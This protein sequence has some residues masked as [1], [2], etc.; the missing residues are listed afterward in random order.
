MDFAFREHSAED[1]V[2]REMSAENWN[3]IDHL[4]VEIRMKAAV[5]RDDETYSKAD[6]VSA[7]LRNLP[8]QICMEDER[9]P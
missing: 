7:L 4:V 6:L 3:R 9:R 8:N 5:N 1:T 2:E